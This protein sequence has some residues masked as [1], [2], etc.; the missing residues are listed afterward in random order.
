MSAPSPPPPGPETI[1]DHAAWREAVPAPEAFVERC[2]AAAAAQEPGLLGPTAVL[3]ADDEALQNLNRTFRG[4]DAPTNVLAFPS[5]Q[6]APMFLGDVALALETC[7]REA[8]QLGRAL[9]DHAAHL[10][11][12]GLLHLIG[13]DH[14]H[15][16]EAE[17]MEAAEIRILASLGVADPY[18]DRG[19]AGDDALD[20]GT[21]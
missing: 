5:G 11:V 7:S 8:A 21:R 3:L 13:Y 16:E 10:V 6:S 17:A 20:L 4:K 1:L 9:S 12:H 15:D 18:G 2:W 19:S 14:E